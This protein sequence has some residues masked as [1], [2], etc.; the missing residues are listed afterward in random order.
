MKLRNAPARKLARQIA[1]VEGGSCRFYKNDVRVQQSLTIKT[2]K[3]RT[4]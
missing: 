1:A 2:K 4:S 3:R